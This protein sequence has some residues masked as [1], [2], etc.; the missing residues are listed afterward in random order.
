MKDFWNEP[1]QA[2]EFAYGIEPNQFLANEIKKLK[3]GKI[4]N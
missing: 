2:K 3:T 4:L 1:Y